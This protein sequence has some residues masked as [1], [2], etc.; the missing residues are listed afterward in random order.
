MDEHVLPPPVQMVQLLTG[1]QVSQAL[2]VTAKL[3]IADELLDG[4]QS[5]D[6]VAER[7]GADPRS[8]GRLRRTL[9]SLGVFT[10]TAT[11]TFAITPLGVTLASGVAGSVRDLA[12]VW[13]ETHYAAFGELMQTVRT[14]QPAAE[15]FYGE[16][17]FQWLSGH[18]EHVTSFTAAM[19][20]LT[21]GIKFAAVP[22][23]PL[24]GL[25][26]LV[27]VAGADGA[28]LATVLL[29]H[30]DV[31]GV[32]FDLPHVIESAPK[33]LAERGVSDRVTCVA[34]D[35]FEGVP[36]GDA[37]LLSMVLHDWA[38]DQS[39]RILRNVAAAGGPGA[40]LRLLE[41]VVP[42]GD[43]PHISKMID[44][45][46]LGMLSGRE[47]TESEFRHL[48]GEAGFTDVEVIETGTPLSVLR[49]QVG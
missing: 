4:P 7:V 17:F 27:D 45:T 26:R 43:A 38:D 29:Q 20:N 3:G 13:M 9:A 33:A 28:L 35:F 5:V 16:P 21:D 40:Q 8:L 49:A 39:L 15:A 30:P 44:L 41:F 2:Y 19:A 11:D 23:I 25:G 22:A 24:D 18:P 34:G 1:F 36:E 42:S 14:G 37:Y 46:M 31:T 47:R 32:L 12:V 48:L 6:S 10:E